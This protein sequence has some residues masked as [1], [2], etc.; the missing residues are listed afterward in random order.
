M[1]KEKFAELMEKVF[2]E[3]RML[4]SAGQK[5]YAHDSENCFD[6][7]ERIA[8]QLQ[9]PREQVLW[10]Y[11]QKHADGILAWIKGHRS[12]R[13][14]VRGRIKDHIV[15]MCLLYGMVEDTPTAVGS[16]GEKGVAVPTEAARPG[17]LSWA[18]KMGWEG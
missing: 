4:R 8:K 10:V 18:D 17:A 3:C 16:E 12:Q 15:Y 11:A 9:L 7:F 1:N 2:E 14:D 5:E 13:E 6:N